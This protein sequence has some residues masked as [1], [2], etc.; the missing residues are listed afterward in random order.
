LAAG[1]T[2]SSLIG[3]ATAS[4]GATSMQ[5]QFY[6]GAGVT[7]LTTATAGTLTGSLTLTIASGSA[8]GVY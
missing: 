5:L 1:T 3:I 2:N 4:S 7:G 8:A 6:K